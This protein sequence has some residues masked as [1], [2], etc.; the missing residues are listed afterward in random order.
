[1]PI[2]LRDLNEAAKRFNVQVAKSVVEARVQGLKTAFLCHSHQ[3]S[4]LAQGLVQLLGENGW[5]VYIDWQDTSLPAVPS[6]A[7]ALKIQR[8][9]KSA[10]YFLFLATP[11]SLA[12]RWCPWEIGYADGTK[13]IDRMFVITTSGVS[14]VEYGSE[15]L[16]IYRHI[17]WADTDEL[18]AWEPGDTRYGV[19]IESLR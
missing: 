19:L 10:D 15:Y 16:G 18:A 8:R 14:G 17:T 5:K 3:D 11:K 1:M 2:P 7:T 13:L 12:S 4:L 6:R 9:I